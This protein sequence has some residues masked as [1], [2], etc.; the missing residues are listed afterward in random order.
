MANE[1]LR[2]L[3]ATDVSYEEGERPTH[4]KLTGSINQVEDAIAYLEYLVGDAYGH[5]G[6]QPNNWINNLSRDIGDRDD[7]SPIYQ[8]DVLIS[9]WEESLTADQNEHELT[10]IPV[11]TGAAIISSSTDTSVVPAQFKLTPADLESI[12]DWTIAGGLDEEG[13]QKNSR[14]L[15][16]F[17]P[18]DG[19]DIVFAQVTTGHGDTYNGSGPNVIPSVAQAEEEG[20]FCTVTVVDAINNIYQITL[21]ESQYNLNRVGENGAATL[22]NTA[23]TGHTEQLKFPG[24]F[25][26]VDGLDLET[27]DPL[28][29]VGKV[30]PL[31]LVRIYDWDTKEM[32]DGLLEVKASATPA[33]RRFEI[34]C[35][36]E[37]GVILDDVAGR[38]VVVC[39]GTTISSLLGKLKF[40]FYNHKHSGDDLVRAI[41]HSDLIGLRTSAEAA[42]ISEWFGASN[43]DANDHPQYLHRRGFD[44]NDLGGGYNI[45]RGDLIIGGTDSS[46]LSPNYNMVDDS[47]KLQFGTNDGPFV[48]FDKLATHSIPDDYDGLGDLSGEALVIE[49]VSSSP[50]FSTLINNVLRVKTGAVLGTDNDDPVIIPGNL[51]VGNTITLKET[52]APTALADH[53]KLYV[54]SDH[55]LYYKDESSN[56]FLIS[57]GQVWIGG[58]MAVMAGLPGVP[59][60][61]ASGTVSTDGFMLCDGAAIPVGNVL[62][63]F[64]PVINDGRLLLGLTSSNTSATYSHT[65]TTDGHSHS[66]SLVTNSDSHSHSWTKTSD[67][68]GD[69]I[70]TGNTGGGTIGDSTTSDSHS[71]TISGTIGNVSGEDGDETN[72]TSSASYTGQTP[73]YITTVWLIRVR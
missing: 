18:S 35:T 14:K 61:P 49:G 63:G 20:D 28:T 2:D 15:V 46:G 30:Y 72:S 39:S 54:K 8:P 3:T 25:F 31:G 22:S 41:N 7:L 48:H 59:S 58:L 4:T 44:L 70:E 56:E 52:S 53:S 1:K 38:Y 66:F 17:S 21:P 62:T 16:T 33:N 5:S 42:D 9:A 19:G 43:I 32:I 6:N 50:T 71:H 40:E 10:F 27:N 64:T 55:D 11:G 13:V 68:E 67:D 23:L 57:R 69:S 47:H 24:Y 60:L 65:H 26:D 36:F 73:K 37:N 45:L 51:F 29:A 12:G 34:L